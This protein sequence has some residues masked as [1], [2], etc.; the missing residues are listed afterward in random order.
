MIGRSELRDIVWRIDTPQGRFFD[1]VVLAAIILSVGAFTISTMPDLDPV[2]RAALDAIEFAT[3]ILFTVEY[4]L[5]AATAERPLKYVFSFWGVVDLLAFLPFWLAS[6]EG[7]QS[8][9]ILRLFALV[10]VLK[11]FRYAKA[12]ERLRRA[13]RSIREELIVFAMIAGGANYLAAAGIYFFENAAQPDK[14]SS[15]PA[16]LWWTMVTLTTVGYGDVYPVTTGGRIFT[17][18][19]L[20]TGLGVIAIPTGLIAA[21][22]QNLRHA[23]LEEAAVAEAAARMDDAKA[24]APVAAGTDKVA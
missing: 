19:V 14:F 1:K 2:T 15:I 8:L 20:V 4:V 24:T 7:F 12:L 17:M 16:S 18:L 22:L 21:A 6:A 13:F 5:R 23:P 10:R 3:T 9:R 11:L